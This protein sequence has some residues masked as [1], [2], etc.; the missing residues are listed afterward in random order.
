MAK[1]LIFFVIL[2]GIIQGSIIPQEALPEQVEATENDNL[3]L[4]EV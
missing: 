4:A 1:K 3:V 2:I